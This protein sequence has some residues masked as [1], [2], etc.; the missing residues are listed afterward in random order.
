MEVS[1]VNGA[2]VG[3][4]S[5]VSGRLTSSRRENEG[6]ALSIPEID[7][8]FNNISGT[9][10]SSTLGVMAWNRQEMLIYSVKERTAFKC[11]Y[12]S[13]QFEIIYFGLMN[14]SAMFQLMALELFKDFPFVRIDIGHIIVRSMDIDEP[15]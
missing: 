5:Y 8:I 15:V 11:R 12:G 13:F 3:W 10:I 2:K 4:K 6:K 14:P 7:D 1:S 9:P